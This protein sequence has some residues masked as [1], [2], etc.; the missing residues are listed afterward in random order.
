LRPDLIFKNGKIVTVDKQ[1]SIC[2]A[3]AI[4]NNWIMAV[5]SNVEICK[6]R[7]AGTKEVDLKG[8]TVIPGLI[9]THVHL[10]SA[11][12]QFTLPSLEKAT[13]IADVAK[14]IK[15]EAKKA[16]PG[17]W[18]VTR[19]ATVTQLST[20]LKEK[21]FPNR[22]DLDSAAPNNPVYVGSGPMGIVN[23]YAL[24]LLGI[25]KDTP[26]PEGGEIKKDPSTGEPIG[27]LEGASAMEIATKHIPAPTRKHKKASIVELCRRFNSWGVT[28]VV[29]VSAY[30]DD[31]VLLQE[32]R[33]EDKPPLRI[34]LFHAMDYPET[35]SLEEDLAIIRNLSAFASYRGF[36]DD[37]LKISGIGEIIF[38]GIM[39][40][41]KLKQISLEAA[42]R[43]LR[44][45]VHAHH[46][47][48]GKAL[49]D[50]LDI[51][52]EVN[53]DVPLADRQFFVVHGSFSDKNSYKKVK[54][55]RLAVSCQPVFL[56]TMY[57]LFKAI[58]PFRT[59]MPIRD[60]LDN[61][62]PISF[63]TDYPFSG[64]YEYPTGGNPM[65]CI[66]NAVTRK[67]ITGDVHDPDQRI[68]R[69]E[70]L[71]CY[72]INGAYAIFE[73]KTRGSIEPGKLADLVVLDK[74]ILTCPEEEIRKIKVLMTMCGGKI[75][76]GIGG[77]L[78]R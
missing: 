37:T 2:E 25:T 61:G 76:Y 4:K 59:P 15:K 35:M 58:D 14:V 45:G 5:G 31:F 18:I 40:K 66:Y 28:T 48:G 63:G 20:D 11:A 47:Q 73:E 51:W 3:V 46:P 55:L 30:L 67:I 27:I 26:Q 16:T 41:E 64:G 7:V 50:L 74:D 17:E 39:P 68:T 78:F 21:R 77:W 54:K 22:R 19:P 12:P 72:T 53:N 10:T 75:V 42:K 32:L 23:T 49:E 62:I 9:D 6:L 52:A 1:F 34:V 70:A 24:N 69:E 13:C 56:Y 43:H 29:N 44:V 33:L 65:S 38:N 60:W 8:K 36:G 57:D 71:R